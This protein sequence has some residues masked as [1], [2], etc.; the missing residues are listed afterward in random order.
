ME[1]DERQL[2]RLYEVA[3][4]LPLFLRDVPVPHVGPEQQHIG[5]LER[6][7]SEPLLGI[8]DAGGGDLKGRVFP[9]VISNK[10]PGEFP[11][12]W[13]LDGLLLIPHENANLV[14]GQAWGRAGQHGEQEAQ[15]KVKRRVVSGFGIH[16]K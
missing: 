10:I 2:A 13:L 8:S 1:R 6:L 7:Q 12:G 5:L 11:V 4:F 15:G 16:R 14:T 9:Q 3:D